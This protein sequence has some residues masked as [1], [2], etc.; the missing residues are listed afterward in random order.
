MITKK[1]LNLNKNLDTS[2]QDPETYS[3]RFIKNL[4]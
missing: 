4:I 3:N 2:A 1:F